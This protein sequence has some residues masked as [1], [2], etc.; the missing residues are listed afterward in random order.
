[1]SVELQ[2]IISC[3][4]DLCSCSQVPLA[5]TKEDV[6]NWL[7]EKAGAQTKR[8]EDFRDVMPANHWIPVE[9]GRYLIIKLEDK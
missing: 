6:V 4:N 1:M 9:P 2:K 3:G 8:S 7:V 5:V